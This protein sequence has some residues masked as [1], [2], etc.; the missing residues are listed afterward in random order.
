VKLVIDASVSLKWILGAENGEHDVAKAEALLATISDGSCETIQPPHWF[1]EVL[2]VIALKRRDRVENALA[3]LQTVPHQLCS[4]TRVYSE[5]AR[6]SVQLKHH[7]FDTLYHAVALERGATL[8]T[9][10]EVYFAKAFRLGNI[11]LLTNYTAP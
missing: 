8:F 2:A 10:D 4:S 3:V 11:K 1:A 7:L 5:A 6:L 9:A